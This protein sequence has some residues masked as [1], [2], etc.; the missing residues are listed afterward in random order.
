MSVDTRLR[1]VFSTQWLPDTPWLPAIVIF[2]AALV[3]VGLRLIILG[4]GNPSWF[5]L[6]GGKYAN[7]AQVPHGIHIFAGSGYDGQF[8]YRLALSP[9]NFS[10]RLFG[11]HMDTVVRFSRIGYPLL[12]YLGALGQVSL[13]PYTLIGVNM[14]A[15]G[16]LGFSGGIIAQQAKRH[17]LWGLLIAGY[18]GFIFTLARDT[19]EIVVDL[20]IVLGLL[21]VRRSSFLIAGLIFC[22]AVLTKETAVAVVAGFGFVRIYSIIVDSFKNH[23]KLRIGKAELVWCLPAVVFIGWELILRGATG[24]TVILSDTGHNLYWPFVEM[25]SAAFHYL[26]LVPSVEALIWLVE[27]VVL[28]GVVV[29]ATKAFLSNTVISSER[30]AWCFVVGLAVS[31]AAG[32][33]YGQVDFRSMDDVYLMSSILLV[34]SKVKLGLLAALLFAV[35]IG[36]ALHRIAFT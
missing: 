22:A 1:E 30:L 21:A 17:A 24:K 12:A 16:L 28:G 36:V 27:F 19:T 35:W 2:T 3:F 10:K 34:S 5:I 15:L 13:V 9:F 25:F 8:Y 32:I 20:L 23:H 31:L 18:W 11:I 4:H 26:S 29:L 7:S 33:W 6:L 14:I